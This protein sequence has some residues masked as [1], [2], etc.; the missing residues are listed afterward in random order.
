MAEGTSIIA[1]KWIMKIIDTCSKSG[2]K[3]NGAL[4]II[5]AVTIVTASIC[6]D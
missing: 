5:I 3:Q 2:E 1:D 4:I 6:N